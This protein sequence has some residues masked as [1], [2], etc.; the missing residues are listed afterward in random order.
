MK[1]AHLIVAALLVLPGV[2]RAAGAGCQDTLGSLTLEK[3]RAGA[4]GA[5]MAGCINR[6]FDTLTNLPSTTTVASS[7]AA[8]AALAQ[9]TTTL[10][11]STAALAAAKVAKAG[12][13]MTGALTI[14]GSSTLFSSYLDVHGLSNNSA[15]ATFQ[16]D[17]NT[18]SNPGV[19]INTLSNN[20]SVYGLR[21]T[22]SAGAIAH[23]FYPN[24]AA[25]IGRNGTGQTRFWSG[26]GVKI[27][28]GVQAGSAS[29]TGN[30]TASSGTFNGGGGVGITYGISAATGAFSSILS[31][32]T[33][34]ATA[35]SSAPVFY[36]GDGHAP[37][38]ALA[39]AANPASGVFF[40]GNDISFSVNGTTR[41]TV[42]LS[43]GLCGGTGATTGQ[44]C[45]RSSGTGTPGDPQYQFAGDGDTGFGRQGSNRPFISAGSVIVA[46]FTPVEGHILPDSVYAS[47]FGTGGYSV[48]HSTGIYVDGPVRLGPRGYIYYNNNSVSTSAAS[49]GGSGLDLTSANTFTQTSTTTFL[50]QVNMSTGG[51]VVYGMPGG[52]LVN[53]SK[54]VYWAKSMDGAVQSS[55]CIVVANM[56]DGGAVADFL[57]FSSTATV[58]LDMTRK[59]G[60]VLVEPSCTP[61]TFCRIQ[62]GGIARVQIDANGLNASQFFCASSTRCRGQANN[63]FFD[64]TAIGKPLQTG[65]VGA[66][67]FIWAILKGL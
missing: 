13:T 28:Y 47:S 4:V 59:L 15:I 29:I 14:N 66:N 50:G 12:D 10:S 23:D 65:A 44:P 5:Q 39:R 6:S 43:T 33:M 58:A 60:C 56:P 21:M 40:N 30:L 9:S 24:G 17:D 57:T 52:S 36:A 8:L 63:S 42:G 16:N 67:A 20:Q 45:I 7:T 62:C 34:T 64:N 25:D 61:L 51:H 31:A 27:D 22:N 32:G 49:G 53:I 41:A 46:S 35:F 37:A 1:I 48:M 54:D 55:G 26:A 2:A 19:L 11:L 18:G 38:P 3:I